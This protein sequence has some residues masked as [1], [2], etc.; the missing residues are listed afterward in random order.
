MS[1]FRDHN[2]TSRD[3]VQQNAIAI[4][5]SHDLLARDAERQAPKMDIEVNGIVGTSCFEK[6]LP[7]SQLRLRRSVEGILPLKFS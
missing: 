2:G 5:A 6:Q 3:D 7:A 1:R 4:P